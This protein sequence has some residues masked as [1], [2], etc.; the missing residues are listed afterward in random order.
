MVATVI[1]LGALG[2]ALT[3][4][5]YAVR[6]QSFTDAQDELDM[7]SQIAIE[8]LKRDLRL[9]S[10]SEILYWPQAAASYTAMSFPLAYDDDGDNSIEVDSNSKIIWDETVIYHMGTN[11]LNPSELRVT[12]FRPRCQT[13]TQA[14]RQR[15]LDEVVS[16][17]RGTGCERGAERS[18]TETIFL[19]LFDWDI[20]PKG[21]RFDGRHPTLMCSPMIDL[22][23]YVM[24]PGPH[25]ISFRAIITNVPPS[26]PYNFCIGLDTLKITPCSMQREAETMLSTTNP[27]TSASMWSFT[28]YP[29]LK[30]D[31]IEVKSGT[32]RREE[33][34]GNLAWSGNQ[35]LLFV[36]T[37]AP[38]NSYTGFSI[39]IQND[40]W[41]EYKFYSA[42]AV[43]TETVVS[44]ETNLPVS[45]PNKF[46]VKL[47]DA[48]TNWTATAQTADAAGYGAAS[49]AYKGAAIR[50]LIKGSDMA[51]GGKITGSGGKCVVGLRAGLAQFTVDKMW[52]AECLRTDVPSMDA[53]SAMTPLTNSMTVASGTVRETPEWRNFVIDKTKTYLIT[54][55]VKDEGAHGS[56]YCWADPGGT[57]V[58]NSYIIWGDYDPDESEASKPVWSTLP[59]NFPV[60]P[61]HM[62]IGVDH[63]RTTCAPTG[64]YVSA[65][66][67]TGEMAPAFTNWAMSVARPG[68]GNVE[69]RIRSA[70]RSDMTDAPD[71][72]DS[73]RV[74]SGTASSSSDPTVGSLTGLP[75]KR[76][77]Q[78][79]LTMSP[80]LLTTTNSPMVKE[81]K[82]AWSGLPQIVDIGGQFTMGPNYG[83][84]EITV[85]GTNVLKSGIQID[86]AL[87]KYLKGFRSKGEQRV[88]SPVSIEV[89]PRNT[90]K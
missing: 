37:N 77:T 34:G 52:I 64:T 85:D 63:M 66:C 47:R 72:Y 50:V 24:T 41:N 25:T 56:P 45:C 8:R 73:T 67:D 32:L 9:S 33:I 79:M 82:M 71:W 40:L 29:A 59:T 44:Y 38:G 13:I 42:A 78:F 76:Y 30:E 23:S 49:N 48:C 12:R 89:S 51:D 11:V 36:P 61:S 65:V 17:G 10:L 31:T 62:V 70:S 19:N 7:D 55:K 43:M 53:K 83:V 2:L 88:V 39:R 84:W 28:P 22:G 69:L 80:D 3:G 20:R 1:V 6:T 27:I 26:N 15:Q 35:H 21:G 86:A 81:V 5:L 87:Y 74:V 75:S 68:V 14:E 90:G 60:T 4:F 18:T 16:R 54:M 57:S 46:V 58:T